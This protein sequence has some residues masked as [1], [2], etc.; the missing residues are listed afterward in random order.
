MLERHNK[1]YCR[2]DASSGLEYAYKVAP[3]DLV[4][5]TQWVIKAREMYICVSTKK[6]RE[7]MAMKN[8]LG[9]ENM[10]PSWVSPLKSAVV[11]TY[12]HKFFYPSSKGW[13]LIPLAMNLASHA[14]TL[15]TNE[16]QQTHN[17]W[18]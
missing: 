6:D 8:V 5:K 2:C 14:N 11:I 3:G 12:V 9:F 16:M 13:S 18:D 17:T 1:G 7:F 15:L 10:K 4:R